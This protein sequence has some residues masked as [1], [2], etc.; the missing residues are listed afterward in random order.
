MQIIAF[1]ELRAHLAETLRALEQDTEPLFI[2][3]RGEPTAVLM[4][5]T[6]YQRL[7]Q[8]DTGFAEALSAWRARHA[9]ALAEADPIDPFAD[10]RDRSPSSTP[11]AW[12]DDEVAGTPQTQQPTGA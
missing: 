6:Q 8:P 9:A 2:A 1:T 12:P 10:V 7:T 3:R 4:S 5:V 11:F